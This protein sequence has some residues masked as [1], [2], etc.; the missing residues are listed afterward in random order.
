RDEARAHLP[1]EV[2]AEILEPLLR[3]VAGPGAGKA[4]VRVHVDDDGEVGFATDHQRVEPVHHAAQVAA[5]QA[6]IHPGRIG[7]AVRD[8]DLPGGERRLDHP[9]QMVAPR[10][11]EQK[12]LG[13]GRPALGVAFEHQPADL[14]R[15]RRSAGLPRQHD[16]MAPRAEMLG[17]KPR[18]GG[19]ARP[20]D[21]LEGDEHRPGPARHRQLPT[22]AMTRVA[23]LPKAVRSR[24]E[25]PPLA[26]ACSA[27]SGTV[28]GSMSGTA[29]TRSASFWP[30]SIGASTGP[31]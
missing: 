30:A 14:L 19:L 17:E 23:T 27:T 11:G 31:V 26:T 21:P 4:E 24:V 9:L 1:L 5:R 15:A 13:L 3:P 8:Y 20:V 16:L 22:S 7:E 6:L 2:R 29:M 25:K 10:R 28:T 18:L 12:D